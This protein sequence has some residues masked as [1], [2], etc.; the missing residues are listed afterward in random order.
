M[1]MPPAN[2]S[3]DL[4][5]AAESEVLNTDL[6]S[7]LNFL[8]NLILEGGFTENVVR[9]DACLTTVHEFSPGYTSER[10]KSKNNCIIW[11]NFHWLHT[12]VLFECFPTKV[13][14]YI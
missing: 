11:S 13:D 10:K 6:Q 1:G 9:S 2:S 3:F 4:L 8:H 7:F 5:K 12:L 14:S